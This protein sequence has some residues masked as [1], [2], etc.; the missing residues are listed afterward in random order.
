MRR[1]LLFIPSNNPG[2][3]ES[4]SLFG[5][6]SV[7]FDLEDSVSV[8]EKDNSRNLLI[9]FLNSK[10]KLNLEV[11]V[12]INASDTPFYYADL[13]AVVTPKI[14]TIMLPKASVKTLSKLDKDLSKI[15]KE[16][17]LVNKIK[18]IPI[19]ELA[20]S[21]IEASEIAAMPRVDGLLLGA[22]DLSSDLEVVRTEEGLEILYARMV[23]ITAAKAKKI[24]AIDTPFPNVFDNDK[25]KKDCEFVKRMGMNAKACIHPNQIEVVNEVFSPTQAEINWATKVLMAKEEAEKKNQGV[26]SL[27]GKM[28]DKP[29][30]LRAEK[31]ILKAKKYKI[32]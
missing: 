7:I 5:S 31:I 30:I 12:R 3:L 19:I 14:D 22:E 1:S 6:D 23:V 10:E 29:V 26:F 15:E 24:D 17:Q 9:S 18:I 20:S 13:E 27:D 2:M 4:S 11:V 25:L 16:K 8:S 32:L 21:L 28:V